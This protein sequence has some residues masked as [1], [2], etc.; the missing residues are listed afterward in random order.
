MSN[1]TIAIDKTS[2]DVEEGDP[3]FVG[4]VAKDSVAWGPGTTNGNAT[5]TFYK[6]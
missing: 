3:L 2:A 4:F 1:S 6:A 5:V